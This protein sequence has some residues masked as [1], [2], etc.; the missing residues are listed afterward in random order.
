MATSR[1]GRPR[2]SSRE[3]LAEAACELFLEQG[4]D[5]TSI[6][7]IANRAGVSRSSF[8][9]YASSKSG[10]LWAGLDE[11]LDEL[12]DD[13]QAS[14]APLGTADLHRA[15]LAFA[16]DLRP[17]ALALA[18]TH[19]D[20]MGIAADLEREAAVRMARVAALLSA[21]LRRGGQDPL[22]ADVIGAGYAGAVVSALRHWAHAG[23]GVSSLRD[24]V[25][26]ALAVAP[27]VPR[28]ANPPAAG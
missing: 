19:A 20:A 4:F 18:F 28:R 5:A 27:A 23:P 10:L 22:A 13:L 26:A 24:V 6:A 15:I 12:A 17:D 1:A 16:D 25:A 11:R 7:D 21:A 9:N 8:F 14:G 3:T 2:A